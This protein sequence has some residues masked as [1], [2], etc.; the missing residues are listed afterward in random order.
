MKLPLK[1]KKIVDTPWVEGTCVP[2]MGKSFGD[3]KLLPEAYSFNRNVFNLAHLANYILR[4]SQS[5]KTP[6]RC[7]MPNAQENR[8]QEFAECRWC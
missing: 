8:R 6:A 4:D 3:N 5:N 7:A 1:E 2:A